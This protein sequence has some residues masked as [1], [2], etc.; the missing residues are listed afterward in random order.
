MKWMLIYYLRA[1]EWDETL[2]WWLSLVIDFD[3][4]PPWDQSHADYTNTLPPTGLFSQITTSHTSRNAAR[5]GVS[6]R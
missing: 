4:A 3:L 2:M 5:G 6:A 1:V